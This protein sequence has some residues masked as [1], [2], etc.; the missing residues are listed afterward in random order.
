M[1]LSN[2]DIQILHK[3]EVKVVNELLQIY[4]EDELN[5]IFEGNPLIYFIYLNR[6][7]D[8]IRKRIE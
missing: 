1:A 2:E 6:E 3:N 5:N 7:D 8:S 4:T